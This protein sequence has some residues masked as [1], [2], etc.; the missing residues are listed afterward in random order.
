MHKDGYPLFF[1]DVKTISMF[2][3]LALFL[4]S[5]QDGIIKYDYKQ[6][7]KFAGHSCP[8]VAGAY[9]LT[10]K[11]LENLYGKEELPTRGEIAVEFKDSLD[12][13]ATGVISTI[14]SNITGA[15]G[16]SGFKG[17]NGKFKRDSLMTFNESINAQVKFIRIDT[18]KSVELEY[19]PN[20]VPPSLLLQELMKKV[21]SSNATAKEKYEFKKLWQDRVEKILIDNFDNEELVKIR[22]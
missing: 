10:S 4:G 3:P 19:N 13:G 12:S 5:S 16:K 6:I 8:T 2:D 17:M 9:L 22:E 21:L 20:I 15:F 7:V 1:N 11:A 14:I 18:S